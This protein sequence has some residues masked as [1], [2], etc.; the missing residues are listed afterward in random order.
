M[1]GK[2]AKGVLIGEAALIGGLGLA[3]VLREIPG[4][5][6][7]VRIWKMIGGRVTPRPAR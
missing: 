1:S 2:V 4:L 5:V 3:I 6:R 7:E